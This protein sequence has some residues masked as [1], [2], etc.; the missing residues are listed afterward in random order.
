[1]KKIVFIILT[2]LLIVVLGFIGYSVFLS[3]AH[4]RG[5]LQITSDP[6]S[7]VYLNDKEIGRTPLCICGEESVSEEFGKANLG[8]LFETTTDDNLLPTGEYTIRIVPVESGYTEFQEKISIGKSVLT[9]VD[10]T[11]GKGAGSDGS[12][13]TLEKI[14]NNA[15][16]LSVLSI[17]DGASVLLDNEPVGQTPLTL[18]DITESDHELSLSKNGYKEK[19]VRIKAVKGY[20]LVAR[21]YLG[22]DQASLTGRGAPENSATSSAETKDDEKENTLAVQTV[23]ILDTGTGFLRVRDEGSRAGAEVGRVTPGESYPLLSEEGD[24]FQI[25]FDD[26]KT[27]WISSEFAEKTEEN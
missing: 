1:M 5:A 10:R 15:L 3:N 20:K 4:A 19:G 22:V 6:E 14:D 27:G 7:R 25:E 9:V 21:I 24:W 8:G 17:P 23:T 13:I 26:G 11:F 18:D 2:L 16:E 12:V